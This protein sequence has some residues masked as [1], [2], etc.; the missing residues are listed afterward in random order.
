LIFSSPMQKSFIETQ[1]PISKLSKESYKERK[2]VAGQTLTGLGKWWGRKPLILARATIIGPLLPASADPKK[3]REIFLKILTMGEEGLLKRKTKSISLKELYSRA[4]PREKKEWFSA[5]STEEKPKY[6][7]G[8]NAEQKE[9]IQKTVFMRMSYDEKLTYCDRPEQIDGPSEK[10]WDEINE[11]LRTKAT[12]IVELVQELGIRRFGHIPKVGDAFCGGGSIPF[13]AARIGCEAYG[14]DLNPVGALLTWASLNIIGGGPE[15]AKQVQKAQ[16]KVYDAVDKQIT[17]WGIEHNEKGWRADAYLYC[18]EIICPECGWKVPLAP[19][20]VIGE[21]T[22]CVAKLVPNPENKCFDIEIESGV[23]DDAMKEAKKAGTVVDSYLACP[24]Q[25]CQQKTPISV[26]R[27]DRGGEYGLRMWENDDIVPRSD[28]VFQERLYC[29]RWVETYL[30]DDGKVHTN[31]YYMAPNKNDLKREDHVFELI[32]ERFKKWQEKGFVPSRK[33]E[34]GDETT[35]LMRER[36]WPHWHHL[37]NPRQLLTSGLFAETIFARNDNLQRKIGLM[38]GIGRILNWNSKLSTWSAASASEKTEQTF[39]NQA[40]NT[41]SN[42]GTRAL[43]A[44]KINFQIDM[45]VANSG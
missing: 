32:K 15:V 28:D 18:N 33:I 43:S 4:T 34:S 10:A 42:Y 16:K 44:I 29:I 17:E 26:I 14:S 37:F 39:L 22:K 31:R 30:D 35:R 36:G 1:F 45:S 20:W 3:S 2:A 23:S 7:K 24:N 11:H 25:K 41:L 38:L 40:F 6:K 13:E 19:S 27:G 21:K 8:L 12:N 9:A 5:E